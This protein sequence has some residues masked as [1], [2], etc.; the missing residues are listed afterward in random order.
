MYYVDDLRED[1]QLQASLWH[2]KYTLLFV[3]PL[4]KGVHA[5]LILFFAI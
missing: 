1:V 5:L 2:L 4:L 3:S